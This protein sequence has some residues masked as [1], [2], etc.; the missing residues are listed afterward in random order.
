MNK[1]PIYHYVYRITNIKT[2]K[3]YYG[4]RSCKCYPS[5]DLGIVYF[6]SSLD[7]SFRKD[8]KVNFKNYK[9]KIIKVCSTKK[10][11][12]ALEVRLHSMFN[13]GKNPSFYNRA[14]QTSTK[15]DT[16]GMSYK[17]DRDTLK[18]LIKR[19]N[20][21]C[22]KTDKLI[23]SNVVIKEWCRKN[24]TYDASSLSKTARFDPNKPPSMG[25]R[26]HHKSIYAI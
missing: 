23:A 7:K 6:S 1:N 11:A 15:F 3:H 2:K 21:Y 17:R 13:V 16:T 5:L 4:S 19:A 10:E 9:Y 12:L 25:N 20:I 14:K 24:N 26:C 18:H 8:Q 22:F